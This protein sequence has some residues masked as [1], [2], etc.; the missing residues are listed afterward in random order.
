MLFVFYR[1][2]SSFSAQRVVNYYKNLDVNVVLSKA[3]GNHGKSFRMI[4]PPPNVT[5]NLHIGHAVTVVMEDS[6][7]RYQRRNGNNVEWIPGFDHAGIATQTVVERRLFKD[8]GLLRSQIN[9]DEFLQYCQNWT[10]ER[11]KT[12]TEQLIEMG[13]SLNWDKTYYTMDEVRFYFFQYLH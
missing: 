8:K 9:H 4:L 7:C 6:I 13:A 2:C 12:I 11:R 10:D 1:F 5:G 3:E